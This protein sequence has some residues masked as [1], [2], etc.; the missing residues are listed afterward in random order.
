M[1]KEKTASL[2]FPFP[3]LS[4]AK[5]RKIHEAGLEILEKVGVR[6]ELEEAAALLKKAGARV[7][8]DG[9]V[10][11]PSKL[12]EKAL[13]TAPKT[14]TLYDRQGRPA[15]PVKGQDCFY[16]PGSD[17]LNIIGHEDG[18]RR[19]ALLRDVADGVVLCDALEQVDF[20]MSMVLPSNVDMVIADRFQ[21]ETML[22]HTSKP[23]IFVSYEYA[24]CRDCV[25]MA[26]VVAGG[27]DALRERPNIACYINVISGLLHNKDALQKLLFLSSKKIPALYIPSSTGGMTSPITPAGSLVMD[28]AGVLTGVVLSQLQAEGAPIVIPGM[29][30]GQLDMRTMV[31]TYCEPERGQGQA[32]AHFCGLPM[33]SLGGASEAKVVDQQAAAEAAL[34]LMSETLAGGNIVH[35][36]G[37]LESGMTFSF[38]QLLICTEIVSWIKGFLKE[39]SVDEDA[40]ALNLISEIGADGQ[41]LDTEH[42]LS[43]FRERWYPDLFERKTYDAWLNEEEKTLAQRAGERVE[44][45]L[46]EHKPEPLPQDVLDKL[47][48]IV[49]RAASG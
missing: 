16:G 15:M 1:R 36:L 4:D 5:C 6:L 42:T 48:E 28:H 24:G 27:S 45:I 3:K 40:M 33:F 2:A 30:P 46:E 25:E 14:V 10:C 47:H 19:R 9:M 8:E 38:A 29:A 35:D 21:M 7:K 34:T 32:L 20:V 39:I 23:V 12:V 31:S 26:E 22:S 43:H 49:H 41:Y 13:R 44:R 11:V 18:G 17:C 37:Y